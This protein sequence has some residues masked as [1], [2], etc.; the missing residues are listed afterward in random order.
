MHSLVFHTPHN[1]TLT[2]VT[3]NIILP[4]SVSRLTIA[5]DMHFIVKESVLYLY[6]PICNMHNENSEFACPI[7]QSRNKFLF[8]LILIEVEFQL[9]ACVILSE[10]LLIPIM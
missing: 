4:P 2:K 6:Y 1:K 10:V 9:K 5:K 8:F 7:V 3:G